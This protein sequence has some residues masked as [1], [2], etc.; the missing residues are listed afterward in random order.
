MTKAT[1]LVLLAAAGCMPPPSGDAAA[2]KKAIDSANA[3]W[4]RLTAA[5]HADSLAEF[6]RENA[7]I[8]PPNMAPTRGKQAIRGFFATLNSIKP[9]LTL[10]ADSVWV[11]GGAAVEQ[12]RW[13]WTWPAGTPLPPGMAAVDSGKYIVRWVSDGGK[14]LIAQDIWNSD[15]AMP[16]PAAPAPARAPARRTTR[17]RS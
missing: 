2:A 3:Q 11:S 16:T 6:Y 1:C 13:R 17:R 8:M 14:W 12:G 7:V 10:R 4:P 9:T 5:G 15:V